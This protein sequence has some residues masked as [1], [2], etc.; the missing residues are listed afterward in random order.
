MIKNTGLFYRSWKYWHSPMLH[1]KA[2][3]IVVAY[4]MY[5][6]CTEGNLNPAWKVEHPIT[7]WRFRETLAKQ[8]LA[9]DPSHRQY[10]GDSSMRVSTKQP[11]SK[12]PSAAVPRSLI[13]GVSLQSLSE[14]SG[15]MESRLCGD[16]TSF[17]KHAKSV[18]KGKKNGRVC[19][20]CGEKAYHL[21]M[22]CDPSKG[23]PLHYSRDGK[24]AQTCFIDYH[25]DAS[26]GLSYRNS[27]LVNKKKIDWT[28]PSVT[29]R[30]ANAS[31]IQSL[32]VTLDKDRF[33]G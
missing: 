6:E 20:V 12:R 16:L 8:M 17:R 27:T 31:H 32:K 28:P 3:A 7:F 19:A 15:T 11:R 14:A 23:V 1:G 30:R 2:L 26:F 9:Y 29:K 21:C 24:G 33:G 10:P 4:D 13:Q 25:D 5:L 18:C 22:L